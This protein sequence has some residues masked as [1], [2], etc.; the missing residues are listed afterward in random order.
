MLRLFREAVSRRRRNEQG[1]VAIMA[2]ISLVGMMIVASMLVDFGLARSDRQVN[3]SAADAAVNAG[4]RGM[5]GGSGIVYSH[6]GVCQAL[7]YLK[8]N[9]E[10]ELDG[11]ASSN[12][13]A[14]NYDK[15]CQ[16]N[17]VAFAQS[18]NGY[19]VRIENPYVPNADEFPEENFSSLASDQGD[20]AL[21]G[22]DQLA[23]IVTKSRTPAFGSIATSSDLVT[24]IRS[25]GRVT[26]GEG[27][28]GVALVLLE[29][30]ACDVVSVGAAGTGSGS[31]IH[32]L[33]AGTQSGN[34]H[35]DSDGSGCAT[36][37]FSGKQDDGIVTFAA[38]DDLSQTGQITSVAGFNGAPI[39][40]VRDSAPYV[41]GSAAATATGAATAAKTEPSARRLVTRF[42]VDHR[43]LAGVRAAISHA[44]ST[45]FDGSTGVTATNAVEKGYTVVP[46]SD[47]SNT[48]STVAAHPKVFVACSQYRGTLTLSDATEV[49][50]NGS[51][52]QAARVSLPHATRVYVHGS[53][54]D[55]INASG[56]FAMH[57]RNEA[58][59]EEAGQSPN[60]ARLFVRGGR[61]EANGGTLQLCNTTVLMMGGEPGGCLP[62][63]NPTS[64]ATALAPTTSPC[65]GTLGT[66]QLKVVGTGAQDWSAPN[67]HTGAMTKEQ[68]AIAWDDLEDLALWTESATSSSATFSIGG[69]GSMTAAGVFMAPNAAPFN[70]QGG[71]AQNLTNAQYVVQRLS[72]GGGATMTMQVDPHNVVTLPPP[73]AFRM[74]R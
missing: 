19:D 58:T 72:V 59:C 56:G 38:P 16:T 42:P 52:R 65:T 1:A 71:G 10:P 11:L 36:S 12:C 5:D 13:I 8:T 25:V 44:E 40:K 61:I 37:I 57:H 23:V 30:T 74:V 26:P 53:G 68:K 51:V 21:G 50:F 15:Q 20:S 69:G 14:A 31:K 7:D 34:I 17:P 32:V 22:C 46:P 35:S 60:R 62:A 64:P 48:S 4:L 6:R 41:F 47:C 18:V 24:Q 63:S 45:V 49:V 39:T 73:T 66:G 43:Y 70:I 3:K 9:L 54:S 55:G 27:D 33:G 29:R 28:L 2:A 67:A